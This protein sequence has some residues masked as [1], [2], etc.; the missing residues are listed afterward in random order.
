MW[1]SV[2]S[3][4]GTFHLEAIVLGQAR[5]SHKL[6][7]WEPVR[8]SSKLLFED[9]TGWGSGVLRSGV[10]WERVVAE[11]PAVELKC[12]GGFGGVPGGD[13]VQGTAEAEDEVITEE[14]QGLKG[15]P[16]GY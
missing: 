11:N 16:R 7:A 2:S 5:L 14:G 9:K 1:S 8:L 3:F 13:G 4:A 6:K 10:S 12:Q 15:S